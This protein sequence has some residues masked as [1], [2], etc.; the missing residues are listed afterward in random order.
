[1]SGG[2]SLFP[3]LELRRR[4]RQLAPTLDALAFRVDQKSVKKRAIDSRLP[5]LDS[6]RRRLIGSGAVGHWRGLELRFFE[7]FRIGNHSV[8]YPA[9]EGG[10]TNM[11]GI[12]GEHP[13]DCVIAKLSIDASPT[14][15][16][17]PDRVQ[18]PIAHSPFDQ[19]K[20]ESEE[21]NRQEV[22]LT[23][24][25]R[26]AHAL[27]DARMMDWLLDQPPTLVFEV[28][29][30][31][32]LVVR[33]RCDPEELPRLFDKAADFVDHIPRVVEQLFPHVSRKSTDLE[34]KK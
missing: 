18:R 9:R 8:E 2:S 13:L 12:E 10:S 4:N 21:F 7:T 23:A 26:F 15:M 11:L 31:E 34:A 32:A 29:G 28:A 24:D 1:M 25:D 19:P 3:R 5:F 6:T 33:L 22:V 16:G 14:V 27:I 17:K 20:F 30:D